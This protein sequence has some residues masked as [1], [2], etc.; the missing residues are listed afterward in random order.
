MAAD[1]VDALETLHADPARTDLSAR[2]GLS[3]DVLDP[4]ARTREVRNWIELAL[5]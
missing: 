1:Y 4:A 5:G 3:E 2:L